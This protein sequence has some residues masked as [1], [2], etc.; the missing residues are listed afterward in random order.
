MVGAQY[1]C[2]WDGDCA[3]GQTCEGGTCV[4]T[5]HWCG[6]GSCEGGE[7]QASCPV[8]CGSPPGE[9]SCGTFTC[10]DGQT[11]TLQCSPG[12]S[13]IP[14]ACWDNCGDGS[15]S[16]SC[17]DRTDCDGPANCGYGSTD[18]GEWQCGPT[19][20]YADCSD[21]G[22]PPQC[23]WTAPSKPNLIYPPNGAVL[24]GDTVLPQFNVALWGY[25]C[26]PPN[27]NVFTVFKG[28]SREALG[29][30]CNKTGI[31]DTVHDQTAF[32]PTPCTF[33]NLERG[34]AYYWQV[35]ASNF[36]S[37]HPSDI[38]SFSIA[39]EGKLKMTVKEVLSGSATCNDIAN[40]ATSLSGMGVTAFSPI[41]G[42]QTLDT[43]LGYISTGNYSV[44]VSSLGSAGTG[45]ASGNY[46]FCPVNNLLPNSGFERVAADGTPADWQRLSTAT[47]YM[48]YDV[49]TEKEGE[50]FL[51]ANRPNDGATHSIYQDLTLNVIST[52]R[53]TFSVYGRS[54][55][56]A[57]LS[58][59]LA[60]WRMDTVPP[61]QLGVTGFTLTSSQWTRISANTTNPVGGNGD[62]PFRAEIYLNTPLTSNQQ[63]DFDMA[64]LVKGYS[65]TVFDASAY[66]TI[67][68]ESTSEMYIGVVKQPVIQ[69]RFYDASDLAN[70]PAGAATAPGVPGSFV[71]TKDGHP[72]Y[73]VN[74]DAN[75]NFAQ[76]VD[77]GIVPANYMVDT[78]SFTGDVESVRCSSPLSVNYSIAG[79]PQVTTIN[80][81]WWRTYEGWFQIAGGNAYGGSGVASVIP[82]S[83]DGGACEPYLITRRDFGGGVL[84]AGL[85]RSASGNMPP[86]LGASP[87]ARI[88]QNS[89]SGAATTMNAEANADSGFAVG[90]GNYGYD[91]YLNHVAGYPA[92]TIGTWNG[93]P[94][95]T[96]SDF[97]IYKTGAIADFNGSAGSFDVASNEKIV[98]LADGNVTVTGN[99]TVQPGGYLAVIANGGITFESN[100][101]LAE[102]VFVG[103]TIA[104][105]STEDPATEQQFVGKG[106]FVGYND[107]SLNRDRGDSNNFAAPERFEMRPDL[108][109]SAPEP[110]LVVDSVF[111]EENP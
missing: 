3:D 83:C 81:G 26:P 33:S 17:D 19:G 2:T 96:G 103:N 25:D 13:I 28:L 4:A 5:E 76:M 43:E 44:S 18:C 84:Q 99:I 98:I 62:L 12:C 39:P 48:T 32:D 41:F 61:T 108:V 93:K 110:M 27:D 34:K 79:Q 63:Y 7:T 31:P 29:A 95:Y 97:Q 22:D 66:V 38:Y 56:G 71:I 94:A 35:F 107:I 51:Q 14:R 24:T 16:Q 88:S 73:N 47:N 15:G 53:F 11:G 59:M 87:N 54:P 36:N 77:T 1:G 30:H 78:N 91:Y 42:S 49:D 100:V 45:R 86:E 9:Q 67:N 68:N 46:V 105:L 70:C 80:V 58:G 37:P 20:C 60:I 21:C 8:D 90:Y 92:T 106:S 6:N 89:L 65:P 82:N 55:S 40:S 64:S 69:G 109:M 101:T 52:D 50:R 75:G 72:F 23:T 10:P 74:T 111:R 85:I 104:V 57:A 102:G